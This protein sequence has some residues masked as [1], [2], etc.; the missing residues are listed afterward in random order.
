VLTGASHVP[1]ITLAASL[2]G[3]AA[4]RR[5]AKWP[6]FA[7][8]QESESG[9]VTVLAGA[10]WSVSPFQFSLRF[11]CIAMPAGFRGGREIGGKLYLLKLV[12]SWDMRVNTLGR[13]RSTHALW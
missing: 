13:A 12:S 3:M 7:A 11:R 10:S 1:S 8:L 2:L 6:G 9:P 5:E 4:S